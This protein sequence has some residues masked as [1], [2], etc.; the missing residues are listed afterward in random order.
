MTDVHFDSNATRYPKT[1][2][3]LL[4]TLSAMPFACLIFDHRLWPDH[5]AE[6]HDS[7]RNCSRSLVTSFNPPCPP[8][9]LQLVLVPATCTEWEGE[10]RHG[11]A[12]RAYTLAP[13]TRT[14]DMQQTKRE[15]EK[16]KR[17]KIRGRT[18][19]AGA[20]KLGRRWG[21]ILPSQRWDRDI[22]FAGFEN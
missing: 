19:W 18:F 5:R 6:L 2:R 17:E 1:P 21:P 22:A 16:S 11:R 10:Y 8:R 12:K 7:S 15:R 13:P 20:G 14:S 3:S 9:I 4:F